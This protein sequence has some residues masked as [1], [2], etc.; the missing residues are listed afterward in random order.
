MTD[1]VMVKTIYIKA[2]KELVWA[3]LTE[4]NKLGRWFHESDT[5]L[6]EGQEYKLLRENPDDNREALCWGKVLAAKAPL[7]LVYT[8][9]H[10]FMAGTVT[11]VEWDLVE[12]SGGTQ[13]TMT[14]TGLDSNSE[15]ALMMLTEHDKG[16]DKHFAR[17]RDVANL[18]TA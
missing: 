16:W 6:T 12:R 18:V 10:P 2:P 5:V 4:P 1:A 15:N 14:H 9:T 17:L 13:L 3:Y 7:R 11:T 8:F